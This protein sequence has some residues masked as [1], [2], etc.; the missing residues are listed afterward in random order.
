SSAGTDIEACTQV[1]LNNE[2]QLYVMA[3]NQGRIVQFND[4]GSEDVTYKYWDL[5]EQNNGH[6]MPPE[7][8]EGL[9][10]EG[11]EFVTDEAL[12][13]AE[14][15]FPNGDPFTGSQK[16]MGG[17]MFVGHQLNGQLWVFDVNPN[18]TDDFVNYGSFNTSADEIAGLH[19]DRASGLFYIWHNPGSSFWNSLE[20]TRMTSSTVGTVDSLVIF[21][22]EVPDGNLEGIAI[23]G[24]DLCGA[25]SADEG[26][27][28]F[29]FSH[30]DPGFDGGPPLFYFKH[31]SCGIECDQSLTAVG[32]Q[33]LLYILQEWGTSDPLADITHDGTVG[34]ADVMLAITLWGTCTVDQ[35]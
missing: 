6:A 13:A 20:V 28:L 15:R 18:I 32:I 3:E 31:F 10:A 24:Q 1:A 29:F 33:E 16:G 23:V 12:L 27:R 17:L 26:E 25:Y 8:N 2:S 4:L 9:G 34:Q 30:D 22:T 19:F 5:E 14:F 21:D 35:N 11:L 7:N